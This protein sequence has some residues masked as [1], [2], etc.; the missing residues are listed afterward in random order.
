MKIITNEEARPAEEL[1]T[2]AFTPVEETTD[3]EAGRWKT[4]LLALEPR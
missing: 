3:E 4:H 1:A 2:T